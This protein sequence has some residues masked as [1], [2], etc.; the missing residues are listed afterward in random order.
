VYPSLEL[1]ELRWVSLVEALELPRMFG[2]V[3]DYLASRGAS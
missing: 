1:V 2:P 3:R